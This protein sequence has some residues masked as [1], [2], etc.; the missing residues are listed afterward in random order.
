[1]MTAA[2]RLAELG[3]T[4]PV[5]AAPVANYVP[6]VEAGGLLHISGQIPFDEHEKMRSWSGYGNDRNRS[7]ASEN[8]STMSSKTI[9]RVVMVRVLVA[10]DMTFAPVGTDRLSAAPPKQVEPPRAIARTH[11]FNWDRKCPL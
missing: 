11:A 1:M 3:I 4:L 9:S 10:S 6:A 8:T 2:D 5:A 7:A